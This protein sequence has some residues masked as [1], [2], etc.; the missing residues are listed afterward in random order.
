MESYQKSAIYPQTNAII[1]KYKQLHVIALHSKKPPKKQ[2]NLKQSEFY[3]A[4]VLIG[5]LYICY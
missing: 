4:Q 5:I 2:K 3:Q 1:L